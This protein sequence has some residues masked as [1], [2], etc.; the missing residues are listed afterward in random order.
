MDGAAS[1]VST[2]YD[3]ARQ[4]H[5]DFDLKTIKIAVWKMVPVVFREALHLS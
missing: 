4:V 5:W 2:I 3:Y 1:Q